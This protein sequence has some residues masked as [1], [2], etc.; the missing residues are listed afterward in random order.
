ME[1]ELK[2]EIPEGFEIDEEKSSFSKIVFKEIDNLP[3]SWDDLKCI[4]GFYINDNSDFRMCATYTYPKES[5]KNVWPTKELA[6]ASLALSQLMQLRK[7]YVKGWIP[8]YLDKRTKYYIRV[9][10]NIP[11]IFITYS[12]TAPLSFPTEELAQRFLRNFK[13]LIEEAKP[14]L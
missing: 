1:K 5:L 11:T 8:D 4:K 14:L 7:V 6:Q 3:E 12:Y 2:I 9:D 10:N 13:D